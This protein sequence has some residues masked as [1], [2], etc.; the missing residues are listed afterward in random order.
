M[1]IVADFHHITLP[2]VE[3]AGPPR[4]DLLVV[5]VESEYANYN[6]LGGYD[7]N[8]S[9]SQGAY[10]LASYLFPKPAGPGRFQV[11]GKFAKANFPQGR[12]ASYNHKTTELNLNYV[13]KEFNARLMSFYRHTN[14]NRNR[15]DTWQLGLGF[16]IQM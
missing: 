16:Q 14:F 2:A 1:P 13:I 10:G 7:G 5:T 8:Y 12:F 6:R 11:L 9:H 15:P 4:N 3:G